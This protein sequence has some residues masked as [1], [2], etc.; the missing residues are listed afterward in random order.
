MEQTM[1]RCAL[2]SGGIILA[3]AILWLVLSRDFA[4][5]IAITAGAFF[6]ILAECSADLWTIV[7]ITA[8]M[9]SRVDLSTG[10]SE[11]EYGFEKA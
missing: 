10:Y 4:L 3:A 2:V 1:K 8:K 6:T 7:L 9:V 11:F 5:T